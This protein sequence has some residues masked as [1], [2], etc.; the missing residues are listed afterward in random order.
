MNNWRLF[1][2]GFFLYRVACTLVGELIVVRLTSLGDARRFQGHYKKF[3]GLSGDF[4]W[5]LDSSQILELCDI[6]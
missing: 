3:S 2:L 6:E 5:L 1:Y 4:H